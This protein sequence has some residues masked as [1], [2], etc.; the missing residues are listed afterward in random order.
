MF[1]Q[2]QHVVILHDEHDRGDQESPTPAGA[3]EQAENH[4]RDRYV[5]QQDEVCEICVGNHSDLASALRS[6]LPLAVIGKASRKTN[7]RG[8]MYDGR[9]SPSRLRRW[10]ANLKSDVSFRANRIT[11]AAND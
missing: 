4:C 1:S 2:T 3:A 8:N 10:C 7:L 11:K 9:R 6:T 5:K